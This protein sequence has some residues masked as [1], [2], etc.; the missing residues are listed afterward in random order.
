VNKN[1]YQAKFIIFF[2]SSSYLLLDDFAGRFARE[3]LWTNQ[4]FYSVGIISPWLF[5]LLYHLGNDEQ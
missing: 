2:A 3:L 4:E 1:I 5:M